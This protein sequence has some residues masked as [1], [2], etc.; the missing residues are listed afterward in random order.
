MT[1]NFLVSFWTL[2]FLG[3]LV[4]H[5]LQMKLAWSWLEKPSQN[6]FLVNKDLFPS[7]HLCIMCI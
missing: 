7:S 1:G 3:W 5:A 4:Y 6:G 2:M